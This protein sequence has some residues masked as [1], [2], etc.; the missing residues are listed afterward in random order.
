VRERCGLLA[1]VGYAKFDERKILA[2][3]FVTLG[4]ELHG[5]SS[6]GGCSIGIDNALPP[7][8]RRQHHLMMMNRAAERCRRLSDSVAS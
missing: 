8:T 5:M 4:G 6:R 2:K 1:E 3:G 7:A